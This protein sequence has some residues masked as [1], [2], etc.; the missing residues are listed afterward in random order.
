M[1]FYSDSKT[2]IFALAVIIS[3]AIYYS[4][5]YE[6]LKTPHLKF[7]GT[8]FLYTFTLASIYLFY[9]LIKEIKN[10]HSRTTLSSLSR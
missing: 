6:K 1:K 9:I 2:L 5:I 10:R 7:A 4:T 3:T 8:L